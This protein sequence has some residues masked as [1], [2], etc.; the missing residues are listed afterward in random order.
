M[1]NAEWLEILK[2]KPFG[3]LHRKIFESKIDLSEDFEDGMLSD[4]IRVHDGN[5]VLHIKKICE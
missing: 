5:Y 2:L 1:E 3:I 4:I